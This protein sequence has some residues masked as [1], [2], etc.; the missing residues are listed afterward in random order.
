VND[1]TTVPTEQIRTA[2]MLELLM[3]GN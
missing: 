1:N 3:T 2:A